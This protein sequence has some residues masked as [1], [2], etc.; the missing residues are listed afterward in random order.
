MGE[1]LSSIIRRHSQV[2]SLGDPLIE[3]LTFFFWPVLRTRNRRLSRQFL[4]Y[5]LGF[6]GNQTDRSAEKRKAGETI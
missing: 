2:R 4:R 1:A 5:P 6:C 3:L